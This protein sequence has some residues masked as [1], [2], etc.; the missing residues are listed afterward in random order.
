[1]LAACAAPKPVV[2]PDDDLDRGRIE[3]VVTDRATGKPLAG[4][5]IYVGRN[6]DDRFYTDGYGR[7]SIAVPAGTTRHSRSGRRR[8]RPSRHVTRARYR[9]ACGGCDDC[10][11]RSQRDL[12]RRW[13]L[14]ERRPVAGRH[15][16]TSHDNDGTPTAAID[17]RA[18]AVTIHDNDVT[19]TATIDVRA[20]PPRRTTRG[21]ESARVRAVGPRSS[22][23]R[24]PRPRRA[25]TSRP[26]SL[27]RSPT[28]AWT[29]RCSN[30]TVIACPRRA[31]SCC[32]TRGRDVRRRS[33]GRLHVLRSG[34]IAARCG[35][36]ASRSRIRRDR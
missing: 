26:S 31:R 35:S 16:V 11:R 23:H 8:R 2:A 24:R 17:V 18:D 25:R 21:S 36:R 30:N 10:G 9:R 12:R 5:E 34:C 19:S 15:A 32:W 6:A 22:V 28:C 1:M 3:G 4:A 7:Y 27:A 14:R 33:A 20:T 13:P 29:D